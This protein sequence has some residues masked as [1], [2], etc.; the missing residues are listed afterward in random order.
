MIYLSPFT[1]ELGAQLSNTITDWKKHGTKP[2]HASV[3]V[4]APTIGGV[5]ESLMM[6]LK[7]HI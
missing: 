6:I 2:P 1:F 3:N 7:N 4:N 5:E